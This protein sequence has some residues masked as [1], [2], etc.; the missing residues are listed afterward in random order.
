[1]QL[2]RGINNYNIFKVENFHRFCRSERVHEKLSPVKFQVFTANLGAPETATFVA[3]LE[4]HPCA[5][6]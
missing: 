5:A 3:Y 2:T 6:V 1:M 4:D